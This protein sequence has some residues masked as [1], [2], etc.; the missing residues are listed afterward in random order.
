MTWIGWTEGMSGPTVQAAKRKLKS[1]YS[2]AKNLD[3]TEYFGTD[4]GDVLAIYKPRRNAEGWKPS[5]DM[6]ERLRVLDYNTQDSLGMIPRNKPIFFTVEGHMSNM[7]FGPVADTATQLENEKRVHHKPIGYENSRIPFDNNSGINEIA[8]QLS[9]DKIEGPGVMWPFPAGTPWVL[10]GFSQGAIITSYLYFDYLAP[11]KP[12][13]W[14]LKDCKGILHYGNPCR[15]TDSKAPWVNAKPGTHGLDPYRRFGL[16]GYP[17]QPDNMVEVYREGDIFAENGDDEA[18][19]MKAAVYQAV[20]K[21][22]VIS[23]PYSLASKIA[24]LLQQPVSEVL[25][26]VMAIISGIQF[27]GHSPSPHYSPYVIDPGVNWVRGL[28]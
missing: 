3:D 8:W 23:N 11:G 18:S 26:I 7:F 27:L 15:Q 14:R 1:R 24:K 10:G 17:T 6:N 2:Y 13:N 4:L 28:L 19:Q 12:L 5:L 21:G 25:A 9:Q 22:D 20:A 16:P